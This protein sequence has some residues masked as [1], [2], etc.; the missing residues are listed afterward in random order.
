EFGNTILTIISFIEKRVTLDTTE[1]P[2]YIKITHGL[3]K[4]YDYFARYSTDNKITWH[5][6][7]T[8]FSINP[9]GG[10][11]GAL[12]STLDKNEIN[13]QFSIPYNGEIDIEIYFIDFHV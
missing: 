4:V 1:G 7:P 10:Y 5:E 11:T 12:P 3:G 13:F 9:S 6:I 2:S 8:L